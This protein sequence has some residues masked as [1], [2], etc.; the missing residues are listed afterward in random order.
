MGNFI[1]K[2]LRNKIFLIYDRNWKKN[3]TNK[4]LLKKKIV[5]GNLIMEEI[6]D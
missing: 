4:A 1:F 2:K 6:D 5:F 3:V